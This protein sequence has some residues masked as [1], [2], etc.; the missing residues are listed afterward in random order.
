MNDYKFA[1]SVIM[2]VY[3]VED[4][5]EEAILSIIKQDV[6]FEKNIQLILVNDGSIDNS[7]DICLKYQ[8]MYPKNIVYKK[9]KN[10]GLSSAKNVGLKYIEGRYVNFFDSDD[11][12]PLNTFRE[13]FRF[14]K[15]NAICVD[16]VCIPLVFFEAQ[17]GLHPKYQY[18]G[19]KNRIID[20]TSEPYNFVLSGAS[21]FYKK[22]IFDSF[23]FDESY[24]GEEDTLLN[25]TIF[26]NNPRFGYVCER[27]VQYNYRKRFS[28]N[29][30]GD[31]AKINP[32][33]YETV[34]KLL[35][36]VIPKNGILRRYEQELIIYELR[37]RLKTISKNMFEDGKKYSII[38]DTYV[39]YIKRLD[40]D[41]LVF[42]SK[43]CETVEQKKL[44]L[45]LGE[46]DFNSFSDYLFTNTDVTIQRFDTQNG[47]LYID[48]S[49]YNYE[50]S[51][52]DMCILLNNN[53]LEPV[54]S[55]D[56]NSPLDCIYG[57]FDIDK[58]HLR[59]Y[60]IDIKNKMDLKMIL[61]DKSSQKYYPM[62]RVRLNGKI[63]INAFNSSFY[64]KDF[65]I[66]FNRRKL[67]IKKIKNPK[68]SFLKS[69]LLTILRIFKEYKKLPLS[70]LY[71]K[72]NKKYILIND[73]L[74]KAGDNGEALFKYINKNL[75]K[76][77][78]KTYFVVSK[79][80]SDYKRLKKY[81]KV[82]GTG[83][84]KHK[85]LFLNASH[86]YS[87]HTMPH[88]YNAYA[89]EQLFF[90]RDL[91]DY[92]FIWLQ[93]GITQNDISKAANRYLK[94][95]DYV[96]T[97]TNPE[98][99]EFLK[100]KYCFDNDQILLTGFARYDYLDNNSKN[101]ITIAPTWRRGFGSDIPKRE[102]F[103]NTDY[104]KN[105]SLLLT[106]KELIKTIKDKDII[107]NFVI[108]PEMKNYYDEFLKLESDNVKIADIN[109]VNYSKAFSESKL[110]ITDYSST[111]FDFAYLEKPEVFFQF[112]KEK[113]FSLHYKKG[114]FNFETDA[115]GEV[116]NSSSKLIDKIIYY[117]ENDFKIEKKYQD[118][119]NETFKYH[120]KNNSKRIVNKTYIDNKR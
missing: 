100:E 85:K 87:S 74:D 82:V 9:K 43:F 70:R 8:K 120:D 42:D 51:T 102:D 62:R 35:D 10:G 83:S 37:S 92:K 64:Y 84:L 12:L 52:L 36:Q 104:Y 1:F 25:F 97:C 101:I 98:T 105:Y 78:K 44:F 18:M 106:N 80:S 111:F 56:F 96:I 65:K 113:F 15:R 75:P 30:I 21:C 66:I 54:E 59:K 60:E 117:I 40:S 90:Y 45:N 14:F 95:I 19:E 48:I 47:K 33:S 53:I 110:F 88:F 93:H 114:Y 27:G 26:K 6:G 50:V 112:D 58:T 4:Y 7:E 103:I 61:L 55:K 5:L 11:T 71:N 2:S 115:F 24:V 46:F 57:E 86:I 20:L 3:N 116:V 34:I 77:A 79:D 63:R 89:P 16:F 94:K 13:V 68:K 31:T 17:E 49:F 32:I 81:G 22:E 76:I 28:Q 29:S 38:L 119:I 107:I 108:H 69:N 99:K 118:R 23:R 39:K 41:Y 67:A 72:L 73:R 91:F 109:T